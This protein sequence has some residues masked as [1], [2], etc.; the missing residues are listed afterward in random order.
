MKQILQTCFC[1]L[2]IASC[3]LVFW[4]AD[5]AV[6][7][8]LGPSQGTFEICTKP[9]IVTKENL[10]KAH[11]SKKAKDKTIRLCA[12][13]D[14]KTFSEAQL[15][16]FGWNIIYRLGDIVTLQG[17]EESAI[18]LGAV[19]GVQFVQPY[20]GI[21]I[22]SICMDSVRKLTRV[23]YVNGRTTSSLKQIY[24]GKNI[25]F[26]IIDME[27]DIHHP[28]FLNAQGK[29]RFIA[30]W[31]QVDTTKNHTTGTTSYGKIKSGQQLDS[32]TSFG[33]NG[34]FHGTL[35]TSYAVG[36]DTTYPYYGMAPDAMII[37]VKYSNENVIPD[38]INGLDWI[39]HVADSLKVPCVISLSIGLADGPHDGTS[40]T[41]RAIDAVSAKPGHIVVGAIGND[42]KNRTH[43]A[44]SLAS[45]EKK[46]AWIEAQIDSLQNPPRAMAYSGADL[47]GDSNK[48][49]SASLYIL[50]KNSMKY[51]LSNTITTQNKG[52]FFPDVLIGTAAD[53][54][55]KKGDTLIIYTNLESKN[56]LNHKTHMEF[57]LASNDPDL[58][59]GVSV[60]FLNNTSGT[61]HG[62][63][64]FKYAFSSFSVT[65]FIDG[66]SAST[67]NEIGGTA[68][69]IIAVGGY[70]SKSQIIRW[71][72][73]FF[74]KGV[75][76][77]IGQ[78]SWFSGTGPTIDG[79]TK[80]DIT[81][82]SEFV[83]G[84]ISRLQPDFARTVIWPDTHS[85]NG[86]YATGTGTSVSSPIVAGAIA[87]MLQADSTLTVDQVRQ[88]LQT[89]AITDQYTNA[90]TIPGN[91]WGWGKLDAY[92]AVAKVLN[93]IPVGTIKPGPMTPVSMFILSTS[94]GREIILSFR[95]DRP[96]DVRLDLF[97]LDGRRVLSAQV[98]MHGLRLPQSFS[99]GVYFAKLQSEGKTMLSQKIAVW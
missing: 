29:T 1:T 48:A 58:V 99:K 8:D 22:K 11:L 44:F 6:A 12:L 46:S 45:G 10:L 79:R 53:S 63:N 76:K 61:I 3:G 86:R 5:T 2:L 18:Y 9:V 68:K 73:S 80:P 17:D 82:P 47:W 14:S 19:D 55:L 78:L 62:W 85:T 34:E 51:K 92:G 42:G 98:P 43:I 49:V 97:S 83:V 75:Q 24:M 95:S 70:I 81:A 54:V 33:L 52:P 23:N 77:D 71:D 27:F 65:D 57:E 28:A 67:L 84:A 69:S 4:A 31:D 94:Q 41:D 35:M 74:D 96:K 37:G 60:S 25:L 13:V 88:I 16:Q 30:L 39:F 38:V 40:L 66:D 64:I 21:P 15:K 20:W 89:T 56:S 7:R 72:G 91:N 93:I 50:N 36:S 59:L 26:G 32:D 90:F 87:L